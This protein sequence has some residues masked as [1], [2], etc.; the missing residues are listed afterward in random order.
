[1]C[2]FVS[3]LVGLV[4]NGLDVPKEKANLIFTSFRNGTNSKRL[5]NEWHETKPESGYAQALPYCVLCYV[6]QEPYDAEIS[7]TRN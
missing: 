6:T 5:P 2:A 4:G 1:M 7:A 3:W